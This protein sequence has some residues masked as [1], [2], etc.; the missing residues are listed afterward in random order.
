MPNTT[1]T[2]RLPLHEGA[3]SER[4]ETCNND[5]ETIEG[6]FGERLHLVSHD[7]LLAEGNAGQGQPNSLGNGQDCGTSVLK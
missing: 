7:P 6:I 1:S 2:I 5:K 3:C 4:G